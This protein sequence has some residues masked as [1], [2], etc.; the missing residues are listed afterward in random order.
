M[1]TDRDS[2]RPSSSHSPAE[3]AH[4]RA[5]TSS[6][7]PD[8]VTSSASPLAGIT[9]TTMKTTNLIDASPILDIAF[10]HAIATHRPLGPHKHFNAVPVMRALERAAVRE[11]D[12]LLAN[13]SRRGQG[14]NDDDDESSL[15]EEDEDG[16]E[17]GGEEDGGRSGRNKSRVKKE[18]PDEED[19]EQQ[20][21]ELDALA[22]DNEVKLVDRQ[23]MW[24]RMEQLYDMAG[25][26]ELESIAVEAEP[27]SPF[28][29]TPQHPD[30]HLVASLHPSLNFTYASPSAASGHMASSSS[31]SSTT[32]ATPGRTSKKAS[33]ASDGSAV[34]HW[35]VSFGFGSCMRHK[36]P[37]EGA[38]Q[39]PS[40]KKARGSN[41]GRGAAVAATTATAAGSEM[42]DE[43]QLGPWEEF[44][45]LIEERRKAGNDEEEKP[46][47]DDQEEEEAGDGEDDDEETDE[48]GEEQEEEQEDGGEGKEEEEEEEEEEDEKPKAKRGRTSKGRGGSSSGR[49]AAAAAS[50][51]RSA[52]QP[53]RSSRR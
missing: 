42:Q 48:D 43:F 9:T 3:A 17:G 33:Q 11:R 18:S 7:T 16:E 20:A 34:V 21:G 36:G 23:A 52:K 13:R 32:A 24:A 22:R 49:G 50:R 40:R 51:T 28:K 53:R 15:S 27:R 38:L 19:D 26:E 31:S 14:D 46:G 39:A 8:A 37:A 5:S 35:P 47:R 45:D 44:Q 29:H 2:E 25:L 12:V 30:T 41:T 1:S 10:L 6:M 4:H